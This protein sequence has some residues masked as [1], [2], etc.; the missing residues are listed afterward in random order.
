MHIAVFLDVPPGG[1]GG[2]QTA[3]SAQCRSLR[4]LGHRVTL[5]A[6]S[7]GNDW[8][9][10]DFAPLETVSSWRGVP[11]ARASEA[12]AR[13]I[14]QVFARRGPVDVVHIHTAGGA[15]IAGLRAARRHAIPVVQTMRS[16]QDTLLGCPA[17]SRCRFALR[18]AVDLLMHPRGKSLQRSESRAGWPVLPQPAADRVVV[19][20]N[21][22]AHRLLAHGVRTPIRVVPNGI[23]D[24][25]LDVVREPIFAVD[26]AGPDSLSAVPPLRILWCGRMS[27][28]ERPVVMLEAVRLALRDNADACTLDVCGGG[29]LLPRA[30]SMV[31]RDGL[32]DRVR[33]H[34]EVSQAECLAAMRI[35]DVLLVP[36]SESGAQGPVLLAAVAVGLPI[37]YCDPELSELIPLGGGLRTA[38]PSA[39]AIA[40]TLVALAADRARLVDMRRVLVG[41]ADQARQTRHT[42]ALISVYAELLAERAE[43][44]AGCRMAPSVR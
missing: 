43:S 27:R 33:L 6:P 28:R 1:A 4:R 15:G 7:G 20:T 32:R 11:I 3:L 14:D 19:P 8:V 24:D 42:A 2:V 30:W 35:H 39:A 29:A 16:P 9:E 41:Q 31:E 37:V 23:D 17:W 22:V 44:E 10:T 34:G 21:R 40:A 18:A 36:A 13:L 26:D 25:L 38:D 5:F 12:N